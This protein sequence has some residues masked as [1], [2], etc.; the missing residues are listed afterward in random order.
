M[1]S[2]LI[3]DACCILNFAATGRSSEI[4][5][6]WD[7]PLWVPEIVTQEAI[8]MEG[9]LISYDALTILQLKPEELSVF[10][11]F[12][13]DLDDGEAATLCLALLRN[14][15]PATDDNK[16]LKV[17]RCRTA[18]TI[19]GT[20]ELMFSWAQGQPATEVASAIQRI[21][22]KARFTLARKHALFSWW[23][24]AKIV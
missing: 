10:I 23:D 14:A 16:A 17:W 20:A 12:A 1:P 18:A 4:L 24:S 11:D 13:Q 7:G 3:L 6:C 5:S 9:Q 22:S 19:L 15:T 21:E 2:P 8:K